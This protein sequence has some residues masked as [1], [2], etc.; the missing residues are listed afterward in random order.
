MSV[1]FFVFTFFLAQV[2][3]TAIFNAKKEVPADTSNILVE[4]LFHLSK[5]AHL[6]Q[7]LLSWRSHKLE[8]FYSFCIL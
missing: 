1:F 7:V 3:W 4:F 6:S 5:V 8:L 2:S